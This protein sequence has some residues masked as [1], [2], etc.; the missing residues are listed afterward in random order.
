MGV[1]M[2]NSGREMAWLV[3]KGPRAGLALGGS[4]SIAPGVPWENIRAL[5][6]GFKYYRE[7]G[8]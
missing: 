8:K 2:W 7:H 3:E 1:P 5:V 6:E 4:S